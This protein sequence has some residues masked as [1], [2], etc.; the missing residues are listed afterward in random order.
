MNKDLLNICE[1]E[2]ENIG[3]TL[4]S[5]FDE[6][7]NEEIYLKLLETS[8]KTNNYSLIEEYIEEYYNYICEL[9]DESDKFIIS[10][11]NK[12]IEEFYL[13]RLKHEDCY[14]THSIGIDTF[15]SKGTYLFDINSKEDKE[16]LKNNIKFSIIGMRKKIIKLDINKKYVSNEV[17]IEDHSVKNLNVYSFINNDNEIIGELWGVIGR[18]HDYRDDKTIDK[19]IKTLNTNNKD[20]INKLNNLLEV[21]ENKNLINS[22]IK[23]FA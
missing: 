16:L 10:Y 11:T 14:L 2:Q 21:E 19:K 8:K 23:K 3:F 18:I 7:K 15:I 17:E 13:K 20:R 9:I 12:D 5:L 1:K 6:I 22:L 4:N